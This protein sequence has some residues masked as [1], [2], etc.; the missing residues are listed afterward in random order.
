MKKIVGGGQMDDLLQFFQDG[1]INTDILKYKLVLVHE[2]LILQGYSIST[3]DY[4][5][6][7]IQS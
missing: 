3:G 1:I 5:S 6:M 7:L 2:I 4:E